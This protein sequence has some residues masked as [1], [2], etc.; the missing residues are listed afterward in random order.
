[1]QIRVKLMGMLQAQT[2][3]DGVLQL[4][5]SATILDALQQLQ[6]DP[7]TVA[8]FTVNGTLVRDQSHSLRAND[9]LV[10]LPPVGGG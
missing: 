3:S 6:V 5:D 2:P 8:V 7:H 9:Q 4:P 1:M 10:I